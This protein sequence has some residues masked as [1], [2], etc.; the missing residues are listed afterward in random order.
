LYYLVEL[1][2]FSNAHS[3]MMHE[4]YDIFYGAESDL[5]S[6]VETHNYFMGAKDD[7]NYR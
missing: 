6:L 4:Q 7:I 3:Y 1:E 2:S 5:E